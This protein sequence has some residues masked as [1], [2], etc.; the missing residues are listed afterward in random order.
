MEINPI[1]AISSISPIGSTQ[2]V[3]APSAASFTAALGDALGELQRL[4]N[5]ANDLSGQLAAGQPV[6]LHEVVLAMEETT[7]A[8]QL[9][10]QVRNKVVEA[11]Q[12]IMRMQV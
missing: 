4:E 6:D 7:L 8:Y 3:K 12:E 1:S 10:L 9:A 2:T 5:H 11:Y